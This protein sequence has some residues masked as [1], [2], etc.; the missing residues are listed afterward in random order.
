MI[1]CVRTG[2]NNVDIR[3]VDTD[4]LLLLISYSYDISNINSKVYVYF[5]T[6][7]NK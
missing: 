7:K 3:T 2:L 1:Q 5:G 6:G 4:V